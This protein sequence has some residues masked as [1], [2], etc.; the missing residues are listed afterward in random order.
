[1]NYSL[2]LP[3]VE[4]TQKLPFADYTYPKSPK[5]WNK[6]VLVG[7]APGAE[8]ARLGRPFVGRSG[9]L[10]DKILEKAEID[11]E[12]CLIANVF[13]Y[14]PPANKID[15]FFISR[16]A[17]LQQ[18]IDI[19]EEYGKF[20]SVYCRQDYTREISHLG[21]MLAKQK[22]KIIIA[23]GRT[24]LWALT[25]ENGLLDKVGTPLPCRLLPSQKIEVMPTYH[26]SFILRGNWKLQDEW[27]KHF[28]QATKYIF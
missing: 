22:P 10:L 2:K 11:R 28:I 27:L 21:D 14:Q 24:P 13:R 18:N 6:I 19:N 16:R 1:M 26:P 5:G 3:V 9:Q 20:G 17:S 25:G 12:Q 15:H 7:E 8:E 4:Q 23:L